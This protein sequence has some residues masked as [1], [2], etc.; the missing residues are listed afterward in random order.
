MLACG[1]PSGGGMALEVAWMLGGVGSPARSSVVVMALAEQVLSSKRG[2]NRSDDMS[3]SGLEMGCP[4]G[5]GSAMAADPFALAWVI[6]RM[7][8]PHPERVTLKM[9][10]TSRR[11]SEWRDNSNNLR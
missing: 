10:S 8:F 6:C 1:V 5:T 4:K 2:A 9:L 3:E 11:E 7:A